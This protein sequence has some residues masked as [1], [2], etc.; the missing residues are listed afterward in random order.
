MH[1]R[2]ARKRL[3]SANRKWQYWYHNEPFSIKCYESNGRWAV[4][5]NSTPPTAQ[6]YKMRRP[7]C[8]LATNTIYAQL[9]PVWSKTFSLQLSSTLS[10]FREHFVNCFRQSWTSPGN[11]LVSS[12]RGES[13][14]GAD[15][16]SS[17]SLHLT[18]SSLFNFAKVLGTCQVRSCLLSLLDLLCQKRK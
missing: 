17:P 1:T 18:A 15:A 7:C 13:K 9:K 3:D 6:T 14:H 12:N 16:S 10:D 8:I 5:L 4:I 2:R 11:A